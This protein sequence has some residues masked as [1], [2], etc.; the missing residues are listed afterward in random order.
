MKTPKKPKPR[1]SLLRDAN[2]DYIVTRFLLS[3]TEILSAA[4]EIIERRFYRQATLSLDKGG[5][6]NDL[7]ESQWLQQYRSLSRV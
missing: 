2:G 6:E 3:E 4:E 7:Y 5:A 1:Q